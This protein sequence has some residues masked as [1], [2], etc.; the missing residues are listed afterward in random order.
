VVV[1]PM[2]AEEPVAPKNVEPAVR[3]EKVP[4][5]AAGSGNC[6]LAHGKERDQSCKTLHQ[7]Q[8]QWAWQPTCHAH[9]KS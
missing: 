3:L 1:E 9:N 8:A 4:L 2:E 6:S 5:E 7:N